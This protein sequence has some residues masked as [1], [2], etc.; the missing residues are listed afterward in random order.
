MATSQFK[1]GIK[2]GG[3]TYKVNVKSYD[4]PVERH[5][6]RHAG[7]AGH[8]AGQRGPAVR[9]LHPGDGK[10][11]RL[12]GRDPRHAAD[13]LE[14]PVGVLVR[15]PG[16]Q[17]AEADGQA[18]V[19]GDVLPRRRAPRAS[20]SSRCGTGSARS[21]ATTTRSPP[22]SR[23]TRTATR[24]APSSRPSSRARATTCRLSAAYPDGLT[25]YTSM[26]SPVQERAATTSSPTS[27][28]LPTSRPCGPSP[29]SRASSPS[30]PPSPRCCFSRPTP[31]PWAPRSTTSPPTPG[32]CLTFHG[33]RR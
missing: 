33:T 28:C 2:I 6:G 18:Q 30:S 17:P 20:A 9:L 1:N 24:S 19:H 22:L 29:C 25:N 4:T 14:H 23:T 15:Q 8:P 7:Q 32:G 27:R 10:R 21:T 12:P 3:T 11:R 16:R 31:T 5:P 13:L 26:I